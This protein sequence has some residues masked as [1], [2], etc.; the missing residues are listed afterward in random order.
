M[1]DIMAIKDKHKGQTAFIA[2]CGPS[3][4]EYTKQQYQNEIEDDVVIC[5]KQ[6][7][8]EFVEECDYHFI[9]DNNLVYYSY[10]DKTEIITASGMGKFNFRPFCSKPVSY[11]FPIKDGFSINNTVAGKEDF[12]L[13]EFDSSDKIV[14]WGPGIMYET[15][16]PFIVHCGFSHIKFIG[17]D[18]TLNNQDGHLNHFYGHQNRRIFHNPSAPLGNNEANLIIESSNVL[19][20]YLSEKGITSEILSTQSRISDSFPRRVLK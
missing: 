6:A 1:K 7:Q 5:V 10:S 16:I 17:W 3:L 11:F 2:A 19:Y 15:V 12:S 13:N 20:D 8:Y 9:N 18:Y 4:Q 14:T